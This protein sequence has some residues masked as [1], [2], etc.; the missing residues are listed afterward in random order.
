MSAGNT[1]KRLAREYQEILQCPVSNISVQPLDKDNLLDEWHG[2]IQGVE[3]SVWRDIVVHFVIRIPKG[4][5]TYPPKV[6]LCSFVPH[7]NVITTFDGRFEVCLDM[8]DKSL[9]RDSLTI[10]FQNWSSAFSIRSILVQLSS[11]LLCPDQPTEMSTGGVPRT[12]LEASQFVCTVEGCSHRHNQPQPPLPTDEQVKSAPLSFPSVEVS[13]AGAQMIQTRIFNRRVQRQ[14]QLML[15]KNKADNESDS[16]TDKECNSLKNNMDSVS[17]TGDSSN[18]GKSAGVVTAKPISDYNPKPVPEP[19][20]QVVRGRGGQNNSSSVF[21]SSGRGKEPEKNEVTNTF[22]VLFKDQYRC[23]KCKK[24]YTNG[25]SFSKSQLRQEDARKCTL[26]IASMAAS[27]SIL[28]VKSASAADENDG[29]GNNKNFL[30]RERRRQRKVA[31]AKSTEEQEWDCAEIRDLTVGE[32]KTGWRC[33]SNPASA[34]ITDR[35]MGYF[36]VLSRDSALKLLTYLSTKDVLSLGTTCRGIAV[37]TDDWLVWRR[38]FRRRYPRSA[39]SPSSSSSWRHAYMLEANCLS[40]D[41]RCF[42]SLATSADDVLGMPLEY[43]INP[44]TNALDYAT[45]TFD[46]LGL[47]SFAEDAVRRT[48]WGEKF[49]TFLPMYIDESHFEKG[50][51]KLLSVARA[52]VGSM[53]VSAKEA[54]AAASASKGGPFGVRGGKHF[55]RG[56][57]TNHVKAWA[58]SNDPEMVLVLLTKMMNTQVVLLCD[59]GIAASDMALTGYCQLHRLLLAIVSRYPQLRLL[60]R[61]RLDTFMYN[62]D[63]RVK[64]ETPSLGEL[65]AMLSVSD[66]YSWSHLG[67]AF[68]L[69]SFDRSVLWACSKDPSLAKVEVGDASRLDRFLATQKVALR[70]HLFHSVFLNMLVQGGGSPGK[71]EDCKD[72]YDTFQGRPPLYMRRQFH[73]AVQRILAF[74]SWPEYF[75]IARMP[76]PSKDMLLSFLEKAVG[77]SIK[78]GYHSHDTVFQNVMKSGVS[79]IL[80]KG[81]SFSADPNLRQ[82]KLL[83]K[84]KYDGSTVFLDASCLV[85]DFHGKK[86]GFVDYH[87]NTCCN[88]AVRHSGDHID[89]AKQQGT[90]T[91]DV[92]IKRLPVSVKALFFTVSAWTTDLKSISQPSCHLFDAM[93]DTEMC[94][95]QHA[96]SDTG[97]KTA[98]I[99]CKLHRFSPSSRWELTTIG[100]VGFGRADKYTSIEED[101]K[102]FI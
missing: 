71:L 74:N 87:Y 65:L 101:I 19:E 92:D 62:P 102:K 48:A 73:Q 1:I 43:T 7:L 24:E 66:S 54:A 6:N 67:K 44:K 77:N 76:L 78:K 82:L 58:P 95:Y 31:V 12:L 36:A 63:A 30:K 100:H 32:W 80:L 9:T 59:K 8:L 38:L 81:E 56:Q 53:A 2:N 49:T 55:H 4:Y 52:V 10:P 89:E 69:E 25:T 3:D 84:W 39:L 17:T 51:S 93:S 27:A 18:T 15:V 11:F 50:L 42:H 57:R 91:I 28:A 88:S 16:A 94:S 68:I 33:E 23:S 99:M 86:T 85:Y 22:A 60:L 37:M 96:D 21:A 35:N 47:R 75:Q 13:G 79:K 41:M 20:W 83:E 40:S 97:N 90:H 29:K 64:K 72:R 45:S 46:V 70:L 61:K 26:C 98:V 5:P 34:A 14:Q